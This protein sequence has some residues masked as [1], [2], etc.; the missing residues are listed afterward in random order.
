[1]PCLRQGANYQS[2]NVGDTVGKLPEQKE[3]GEI[4]GG[5]MKIYGSGP[6][7]DKGGKYHF[8]ERKVPYWVRYAQK[9]CSGCH[10]NFYNDGITNCTGNS[11][12]FSLKKSYAN[13]KTRPSCYH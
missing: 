13:R 10:D 4:E 5:K 12:C 9:H 7:E 11:W 1:M 6:Y 8:E 3:I 2:V